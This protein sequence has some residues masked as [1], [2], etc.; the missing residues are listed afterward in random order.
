MPGSYVDERTVIAN[1]LDGFSGVLLWPDTKPADGDIPSPGSDPAAPAS[2]V[3]ADVEYDRGALV[4]MGGTEQVDGRVILH[5]W[6]ERNSGDDAV[7]TLVET[8]RTL[9]A[10]GTDTTHACYFLAPVLGQPMIGGESEEWYGRRMEVPF[11]RF[12][13]G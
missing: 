10:A 5:V 2:Y 12:R 11:I 6:A 13:E 8:L 1:V 7:R 9:F 3:V 4:T